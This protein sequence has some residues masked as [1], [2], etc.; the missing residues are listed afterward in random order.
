MGHTGCGHMQVRITKMHRPGLFAAIGALAAF[1]AAAP[2]RASTAD[3]FAPISC[4]NGVPGG[5]NCI[6]SARDVK[7][8]HIAFAKGLKLQNSK[9]YEDAF[10]A[11][12]E[13]SRLVPQD[14]EYLSARELLKSQ[15]VFAHNERGNALLAESHREAA[16]AEFRT[17][18]ALDPDNDSVRQR[19]AEALVDPGSSSQEDRPELLNSAEIH[20]QPKKDSATFRYRGDVRGMYNELATAYG[21]TVQFDDSVPAKP[22]RFFVEDVDFFTALK[23]AGR[24]SK[25]MWTPLDAHQMLIAADNPE[26]HRQFDQMSLG[27]FLVPASAGTPQEAN[28]LVLA[29][30]NVC[31]FQKI[32][33]GQG[34][35]FDVRAPQ[36]SLAACTR[37]LQQLTNGRPQVM[38]DVRVFQISHNL[39]RN[40]GLHIPDTF[41]ASSKKGELGGTAWTVGTYI[42]LNTTFTKAVRSIARSS[43]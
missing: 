41:N 29:I 40:I 28:E 38:I 32:T 31:D 33:S 18:L 8:A 23:L 22:V 19:L 20:L 24:V 3:E 25:T 30:R 37:L 43:A 11:F 7:Q 36:A 2:S 15:L 13:A 6:P 39:T 12:D 27:T 10:A 42:P 5:V 9:R 26:N 4:G 17:A 35:T 21:L 1:L 14:T 16:A 34:G